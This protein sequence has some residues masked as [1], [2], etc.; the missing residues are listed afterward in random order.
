MRVVGPNSFGM[1]NADPDVK[2]NAS[3]AP[4]LPPTGDFGLFSQSGALGIA[5]LASATRRGLGVSSF[6]SAGNRADLSGNDMMQYWEEDPHTK[7]VGLYL[8]SI[9]N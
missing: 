1:L 9:G 5:V 6:V 8:E 2:L 4:F 3:L 7:A